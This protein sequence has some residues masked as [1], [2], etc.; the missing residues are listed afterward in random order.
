LNSE[1]VGVGA[2]TAVM[3]KLISRRNLLR[4]TAVVALSVYISETNLKPYLATWHLWICC[5]MQFCCNQQDLI[6]KSCWFCKD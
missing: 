3:S 1:H 4:K 6:T 2:L 5:F